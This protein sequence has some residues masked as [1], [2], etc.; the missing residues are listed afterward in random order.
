MFVC[1]DELNGFSDGFCLDLEQLPATFGRARDVAVQLT[2]LLVSRHHCQIAIRN[3][4]LVIRDLGSVNGTLL[5]GEAVDEAPL[6]SGDT[7]Q[8]G[9]QSFLVRCSQT[10]LPELNQVKTTEDTMEVVVV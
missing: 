3:N 7:L 1:F 2:N 5:N 10:S 9:L 4:Q 6:S 8:V